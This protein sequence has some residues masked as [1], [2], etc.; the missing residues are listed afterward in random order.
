MTVYFGN[1]RYQSNEQLF[2]FAST[3]RP[4]GQIR[5]SGLDSASPGREYNE[6]LE[7]Y[8]HWIDIHVMLADLLTKTTTFEQFVNDD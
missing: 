2:R 6:V 5:P 8:P 7:Y 4:S 1:N 3:S